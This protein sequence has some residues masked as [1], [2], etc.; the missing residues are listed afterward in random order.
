MK[1]QRGTIPLHAFDPVDLTAGDQIA[2]RFDWSM[3]QADRVVDEADPAFEAGYRFLYDEFHPRGEMESREV[4]ANRLKWDPAKPENGLALLYEMLVITS[5][6]EVAA[7]RDHTAIVDVD[8]PHAPAVVHL[9]HVLVEKSWRGTGLGAW[10]RTL[11]IDTARGCMK[12][13]GRSEFGPI[14]LVGEMEHPCDASQVTRLRAYERAGFL[15]IDPARVPYYQPDFRSASEIDS[16]GLQPIPMALV[17]R[18]VGLEDEREI[19]GGEVRGIVSALYRMFEMGFRKQDMAGLW[20]QL[21]ERYP[22]NDEM[23]SLVPP[24]R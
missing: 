17:V 1:Y 9:S 21:D 18:R 12:A 6:E 19:T 20:T 5:Q 7:V 16:T 23:V 15:K 2:A 8:H 4:I 14:V 11:P 22:K 24:T 10:L 3:L 13:A